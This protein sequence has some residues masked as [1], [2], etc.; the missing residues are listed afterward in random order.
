MN[1][2]KF[3]LVIL[4]T[5]CAFS[6]QAQGLSGM[7]PRP[8]KMK[9]SHHFIKEDKINLM[10]DANLAM[11]MIK[12]YE[13]NIKIGY[14]E[15]GLGVAGFIYVG[16][17]MDVPQFWSNNHKESIAKKNRN[18]RYVGAAISALF[19]IDGVLRIGRN[20]KKLSKIHWTLQP[21]SGGIKFYF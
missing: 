4:V 17:F 1:G 16:C 10:K 9:V 3:I 20:H 8:K 19:V 7:A 11:K 15:T 18:A 5:A 12:D 21:T 13:A 6:A 2:L 14:A